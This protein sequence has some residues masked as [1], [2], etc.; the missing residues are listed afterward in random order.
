MVLLKGINWIKLINL[1]KIINRLNHNLMKKTNNY[2]V[3][4]IAILLIILS[5]GCEEEDPKVLSATPLSKDVTRDAGSFIVTIT[6][7][8]D[9][10]A[11]SSDSWCTVSPTSGKGD[12]TLTITYSANEDEIPRN[13]TITIT[14]KLVPQISITITQERCIQ[15]NGV[16][17][18]DQFYSLPGGEMVYF[19][20]TDGA[21]NFDVYLYQ[22]TEFMYAGIY[23]WFWSSSSTDL[24]PGTYSFSYSGNALTF[25]ECYF[26]IDTKKGVEEWECTS[27][28]V[29]VDKIGAEYIFDA[30]LNG[31]D[32]SGVNRS[33]TL[34]YRGSLSYIDNSKTVKTT[35]K[36]F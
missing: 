12:G 2:L 4:I 24:L 33:L 16:T 28:T 36:G 35:Q 6:G 31:I 25:E 1:S 18:K 21:Y 32:D 34:Y 29:S 3:L 20:G 27:G 13:A 15:S 8:T 9:W 7:N 19:G 5:V 23:F 10:I 14:G 17:Y 26:G 30:S 22:E 11:S